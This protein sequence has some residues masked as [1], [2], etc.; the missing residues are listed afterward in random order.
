MEIL[1]SHDLSPIHYVTLGPEQSSPGQTL[2]FLHG[3]TADVR[4]WLPFAT[5][6]SEHF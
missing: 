4:E 6:L 2:I 5:P 3:W 1:T